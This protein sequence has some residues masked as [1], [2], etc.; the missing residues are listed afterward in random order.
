MSNFTFTFH[1]QALGKGGASGK[2]PTC[3][4]RRCK[5]RR[6]DSRVGRSPGGGHSNPSQYSYLKNS[7]DREAWQVTVH[8]YG[9]T[10]LDT[11]EAT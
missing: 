8:I 3:Q 1:F 2:E 6:F 10:E 4:C 9:R 7:M 5:R 11:T